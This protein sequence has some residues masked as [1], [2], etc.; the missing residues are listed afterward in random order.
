MSSGVS[1]WTSRCQPVS[2]RSHAGS[3]SVVRY[4]LALKV[5]SGRPSRMPLTCI[6]CAPMVPA[7][8]VAG[9]DVHVVAGRRHLTGRLDRVERERERLGQDLERAGERRAAVRLDATRVEGGGVAPEPHE[10]EDQLRRVARRH[11]GELLNQQ[12]V[13]AALQRGQDERQ[14]LGDEPRARARA[15]QRGRPLARRPPQAVGGSPGSSRA[16]LWNSLPRRHH[17]D[18]GLE[19]PAQHVDVHPVGHVEDAVR[20]QGEDLADVTGGHARRWVRCRTAPRRR[21]PPCPPSRR[22]ARRGRGSGAQ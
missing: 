17:V 11:V 5:S 8:Q 3:T 22:T 16:G 2:R 15:V 21:A 20:L 7:S 1:P 12:M 4:Q 19:Q 9:G 6:R 13:Q 14:R 10:V 18:A